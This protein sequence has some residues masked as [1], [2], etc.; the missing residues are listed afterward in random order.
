MSN[1]YSNFT[2]CYSISKTL[3]FS[4]I[5]QFETRENILK[6]G[7]LLSDKEKSVNYEKIKPILDKCHIKYI[8]KYMSIYSDD[9]NELYEALIEAQKD[10]TKKQSLEAVQK[11]YRKKISTFLKKESK[12]LNPKELIDGAIKGT[13][14][15]P[16]MKESIDLFH[17]FNKFSTYFI[18]YQTA[19]DNMYQE[20]GATA[21]AYRVVNEIFPQFVANMKLFNDLPENVANQIENDVEILVGSHRLQEIFS[22]DFFNNV[23]SQNGIDFY[24]S[25]IG[26]ITASDGITKQKG[27]NE[28]CNICY[29]KGML[30]KKVV[31]KLLYKQILSDRET[32]SF[33]SDKFNS[34]KELNETLKNYA[35]SVELTLN[36]YQSALKDCFKAENVETEKIYIDKKMVS[37]LSMIAFD[38]DWHA[39]KDRLKE[40]KIKDKDEYT[41]SE[42]LSICDV[43]LLAKAY[44]KIEEQINAICDCKKELTYNAKITSYV[45]IKKYMD[46]VQ[47]LEKLLK[48]FSSTDENEKDSSFYGVYDVVYKVMRENIFLYNMIRNYATKAPYSTE[49]YKLTFDCSSFME[50]WAQEYDTNGALVLF[51]DGKYYLLVVKKKLSKE[52]KLNLTQKTNNSA[53][54]YVYE[55]LKTDVKNLSRMF[56]YSKTAK[57]EGEQNVVAPVVK[58]YNLPI[59]DVEDIY[60]SKHYTTKHRDK[61][62]KEYRN[63]LNK[64]IDYYKLGMSKHD[65]F[66]KFTLKWKESPDYADINEFVDDVSK[67]CYKLSKE[68]IDFDYL[69]QLVKEDKVYLFQIYNKDFSEKSTGTPN[70][71][72]IYWKELFSDENLVTPIF[73]LNGAAEIFYRPASIENPFVHTE[74]SILVR[75]KDKFGNNVQ[76]DIYKEAISKIE[77][78]NSIEQLEKEF[79]SLIF[80]KAPHDIVKDKRYSQERISFHVPIT[81]N[82]AVD[83]KYK[84]FNE[85]VLRH[86]DGNEDVHI[87]GID[88]GER[89]LIYISCI[90]Q[91]GNI[92]YQKSFNTVSE[93][94]YQDKLVTLEKQR[95]DE[96]RSWEA[97]TKIKDVK[98]GYLSQVVHEI[99]KLMMK[100]PSI[101]AMEDLNFGFKQGRMHIERQVYQNFEKALIE[102]LNYCVLKD[103]KS[104][105][106]G[107]VRHAYQLTSKFESF[108]KLGKLSGK[109]SGFIFYVPARNT[110]KIDYQTGFVNLFT[111]NQLRYESVN[112]SKEFLALFDDISYD[113]L[114]CFR[115]DFK[116]SNFSL[117]QTDYKDEWSIY[118]IG[119]K[120]IAHTKVDGYDTTTEIDVT[121]EMKQLFSKY[122]IDYKS[123]LKQQIL[124][125]DDKSFFK[126][127]LWLISVTVQLR[128]E[129]AENDFILSPVQK[130]GKFFD[131]RKATENEPLDGDANGAY[132][133]AIKGLQL[134]K[135]QIQDG[136]IVADEKGKQFYNFLKFVQDKNYQ[137]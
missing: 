65:D 90:D 100:Y 77:N 130:N 85:S 16:E 136:K 12:E 60:K 68:I 95:L 36:A 31:F 104:N 61:N 82:N 6:N 98:A 48:I 126:T 134:L 86:I 70:L 57:R 58:K 137:K 121:A 41:L 102:K 84:K 97:V 40:N 18:N 39:L 56:F 103:K 55:S 2:N 29:Q 5:P 83:E 123:N 20:D 107:G 59:K 28:S 3:R 73:K 64:I 88:R 116:Y 1:L 114:D 46:S 10:K 35:E 72:T 91:K 93:T 112:K 128:Y 105:E 92:I 75:K 53:I 22:L 7:I 89:N 125:V 67:C 71:H 129:N 135:T 27:I 24:N 122:G 113:K 63:A 44:E 37:F 106:E 4:L 96:R 66:K 25:I 49:K 45:E 8:D 119:E 110:S 54:R 9:W 43:D 13:Y 131:T 51:K 33:V 80:R 32:M 111:S 87:I 23:L 38:N 14:Y 47:S 42:L 132:H 108:E 101:I 78:G 50:V 17:S 76:E 79:P 94:D 127:L 133:I 11:K 52:E 118:T 26:G 15:V 109:Q 34:D 19:R 99:V 115:F 30:N 81:M 120:R 62:E 74:N 117:K 124:N 69:Q 21:I